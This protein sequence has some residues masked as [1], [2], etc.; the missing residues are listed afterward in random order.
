M[1][2]DL[3]QSLEPDLSEM[4]RRGYSAQGQGKLEEAEQLYC[5]IL[6]HVPRHFDAL[7]LLG[8]LN[9]QRGRLLEALKL[10]E[11]ALRVDEGHVAALLKSRVH[12]ARHGSM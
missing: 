3:P 4:L 8:F 5:S 6:N 12:T 11:A 10:V 2:G 9:F 7:H 1:I